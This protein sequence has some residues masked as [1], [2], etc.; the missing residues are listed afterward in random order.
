[1]MDTTATNA[2]DGS[3]ENTEEAPKARGDSDALSGNV[4]A[5]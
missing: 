5:K 2:E 1:M 3:K 4:P